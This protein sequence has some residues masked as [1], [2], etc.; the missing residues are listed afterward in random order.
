[1][2][3][4]LLGLGWTIDRSDWT[5]SRPEQVRIEGNQ[6][7]S[8]LTVRSMLAIPYPQLIMELAPAQLAARLMQRSSVANVKIDRGVLPPHLTVQIQDFPPV[9][10]IMQ[11]DNHN[12]QTFIDE[13]GLK[14]PLA[15]YR[16]AVWKSLPLYN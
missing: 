14:L 6:Y 11:T 7:L 5:I 8:D 1:M 12:A 4:I 15:S 9:A 3:G 13:R 2:S 16:P 10:R